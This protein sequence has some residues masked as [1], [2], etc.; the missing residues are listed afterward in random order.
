[1]HRLFGNLHKPKSA[2]I[3]PHLA[4]AGDGAMVAGLAPPQQQVMRQLVMLDRKAA[5]MARTQDVMAMSLHL[6]W[7]RQCMV[8]GRW[9]SW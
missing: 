1:V 2:A 3:P 7:V 5:Q 8:M 4:T 9:S 6:M